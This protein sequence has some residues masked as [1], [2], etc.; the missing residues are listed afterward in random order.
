MIRKNFYLCLLFALLIFSSCKSQRL[1]YQNG[2][3]TGVSS[4]DDRGA[5]G[6]IEITFDDDKITNCSFVTYQKDGKIKGKD[7]GKVNG[8]ITNRDYYE[9][10]QLAVAAMKE[11]ALQF[12]RAQNLNGVDVIAGATVAYDQFIEAAKEALG[13][14]KDNKVQSAR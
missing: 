10:A 6:E 3:Y 11:Y 14:A 2:V 12:Q 1:S 13:K 4:K 5:Y 7:Y 8:E 9:K